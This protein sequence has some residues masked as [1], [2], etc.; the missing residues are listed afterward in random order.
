MGGLLN[1]IVLSLLP[2]KNGSQMKTLSLAGSVSALLVIVMM[3]FTT[4][5]HTSPYTIKGSVISATDQQP[6]ERV[7]ISAVSGEEET[8]TDKNGNFE[9]NTWQKL[10]VTLYIQ[11]ADYLAEK[12]VLTDVSQ[13]VVFRLKKK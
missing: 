3:S 10:P 12:V 11:H 7:Y 9:L 13:K 1:A 4:S 8:L 6:L 2:N 5:R